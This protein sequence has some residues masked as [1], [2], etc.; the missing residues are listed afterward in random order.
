M[1][2]SSITSSPWHQFRLSI[3]V[4]S[5]HRLH[6]MLNAEIYC[7]YYYTPFGTHSPISTY[8]YVQVAK[9]ASTTL[10]N[11]SFTAF[12]FVM[13]PRRVD[14]YLSQFPLIIEVWKKDS[15]QRD[16]ILGHATVDVSKLL[17]SK[18]RYFDDGKTVMKIYDAYHY[19]MKSGNERG[20]GISAE[21]R[22]IMA[23]ED[24]GRIEEGCPSDK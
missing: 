20:G 16:E 14:E 9:S 23:I 24:F 7:T 1:L 21:L 11:N 2:N 15:Y 5:I 6:D 4:K 8:P 19:V 22:V 18:K 12:D 3:D 17:S 10:F 13:H